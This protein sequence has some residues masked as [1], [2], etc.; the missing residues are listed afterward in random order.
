MLKLLLLLPFLY[1]ATAQPL[2]CTKCKCNKSTDPKGLSIECINAT[3]SDVFFKNET[4]LQQDNATAPIIG[5]RLHRTD[6]GDLQ[7]KFVTSDL[8]VLDL[9]NNSIGNISEG[10]FSGLQNMEMLILS[11]NNIESLN[12]HIFRGVYE[13]G[14]FYPMHSLRV[15]M[16]CNNKMHSLDQSLFEHTPNIETLSL[17]GNPLKVLDANTVI[18]IGSLPYLKEL[19]LSYTQIAELPKYFLHTPKHLSILN[20]SG[21][22]FESVPAGLS[23]AHG[24]KQLF[25][26]E[27]PI[28][29][30]THSM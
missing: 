3:I 16:L 2:L 20:L 21:N 14:Y 25:F 10:V 17:S 5:V 18:A 30:L 19:D 12:P 24:L 4:W 8:V 23:D 9:S 22:N 28:V 13:P 27:N 26:N 15:L 6:I 1:T 29:N 7:T 11:D